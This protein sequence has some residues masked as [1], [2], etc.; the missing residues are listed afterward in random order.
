MTLE[1]Y[2]MPILENINDMPSS[3][4]DITH[5][6]G[7]L[8]CKQHN[9]VIEEIVSQVMEQTPLRIVIDLVN[10]T[11]ISNTWLPR[12]WG[13]HLYAIQAVTIPYNSPDDDYLISNYDSNDYNVTMIP[14]SLN[15]TQI[16][17]IQYNNSETDSSNALYVT[18]DPNFHTVFDTSVP[19]QKLVLGT[20]HYK[21]SQN[22]SF[23]KPLEILFTNLTTFLSIEPSGFGS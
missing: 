6:N 16:F 14:I 11:Q 2:K 7:S 1:Q 8:F 20:L 18:V 10:N 13:L 19:M 15:G 4:G 21:D 5:P 17:T 9:D 12:T 23:F 3:E 22:N